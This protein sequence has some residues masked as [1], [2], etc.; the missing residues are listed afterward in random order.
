MCNLY[1]HMANQ[2]AI[3]NFIDDFEDK[4]GNL[5]QYPGIYPDY[6]APIIRNAVGGREL[7]THPRWGM[8]SSKKA[9]MEAAQKR[10]AKLEAKG[11]PYDF[12]E[13]YR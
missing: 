1:S 8:P 5:Q 11:K 12:N 13:P 10:A 9:V 6:A 3:R 2:Q 4:A 7:V